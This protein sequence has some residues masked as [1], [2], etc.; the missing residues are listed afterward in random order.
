MPYLEPLPSIY[1]CRNE[2]GQG[3]AQ[4]PVIVGV[5]HDLRGDSC[6]Y[7]RRRPTAKG[8]GLCVA[9]S[10]TGNHPEDGFTPLKTIRRLLVVI[11]RR[12]H[13]GFKGEAFEPERRRCVLSAKELNQFLSLYPIPSEYDVIL[14]TSTQTIFDAPPGYVGL[15][16]KHIPNLLPKVITRIE[17]WH[18]R[19]FFVQDSIISSKYPQLL[20]DENKLNLKSFKDKLPPN[21]DENPYFQRLGRYPISV[22]VFD[23]PILFLAGLKPSWEFGQQR[24]AIIVGGKEMAFRNFIYTEDD[25]DLTFLPKEPS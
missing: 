19:F 1:R 20:L 3:L 16:E 2:M 21:I 23:D 24:P 15:S 18:E 14:P 4:R 25:D 8:V 12:S 5:S 9:D 11:R 13:S 22:R 7:F 10:H 6:G 17:G